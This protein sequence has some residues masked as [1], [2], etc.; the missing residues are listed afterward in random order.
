MVDITLVGKA[1]VRVSHRKRD[2]TH[3]RELGVGESVL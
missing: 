2:L 3:I 1:S